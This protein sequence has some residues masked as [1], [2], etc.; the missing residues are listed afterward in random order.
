MISDWLQVERILQQID[1]LEADRHDVA[2]AQDQNDHRRG[3]DARDVDVPDP[4]AAAMRRQPSPTRTAPGRQP[5]APPDRSRRSS[6]RSAR[7]RTRR[8][9][10]GSSRD[11][12]ADP[13]PGSPTGRSVLVTMPSRGAMHQDH[14]RH[15][16]HGRDEVR[17]VGDHLHGLA[18]AADPDLVQA[19]ARMIGIG[20]LGQHSSSRTAAGCS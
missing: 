19:S 20:K 4:S 18:E 11:C 6:R 12:P 7:R 8:R 13:A 2:H 1:L 3:Q 16:H 14:H 15:D 17:R 10:A 9:S 5:T